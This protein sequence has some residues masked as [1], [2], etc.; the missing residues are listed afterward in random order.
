MQYQRGTGITLQSDGNRTIIRQKTEPTRTGQESFAGT[1]IPGATGPTGAPGA[2]GSIGPPGPPGDPGG[3]PGPPGPPGEP[4]ETGP[5]GPTGPPGPTG[6]PGPPGEAGGIGPP[7]P[8][9]P[10]DSII[11]NHLGI[12]AFACAEATQPLFF[13]IRN[14]GQ[15]PTAKF[16]AAV[17]NGTLIRFK[18]TNGK[19]ELIFGVR[20]GYKKWIS[21]N[22]TERA[23]KQANAFWGLAFA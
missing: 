6:D 13:E 23:M 2:A 15:K 9:G 7:G 18:S 8:P 17:E 11:K 12:Y 5:V 19:K 22:K 3:P 16:L 1:G 4:G 20:K 14:R 10:K 21:P